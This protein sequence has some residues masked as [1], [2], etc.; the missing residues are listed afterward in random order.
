MINKII[1]INCFSSTNSF[2]YPFLYINGT[3]VLW[4]TCSVSYCILCIL[5]NVCRTTCTYEAGRA[6]DTNII[7]L[8]FLK[9][10]CCDLGA[11]RVLVI[12]N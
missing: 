7:G 5:Y 4:Y 1:A 9:T 12:A 6:H 8:T 10:S 3:P 2:L 11:I